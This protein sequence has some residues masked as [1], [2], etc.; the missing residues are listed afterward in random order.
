VN[1]TNVE[2]I[3]KNYL[4]PTNEDQSITATA[5]SPCEAIAPPSKEYSEQ[6][7]PATSAVFDDSTACPFRVIND[8][9]LENKI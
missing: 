4:F 3:K 5:E 6:L 7:S 2:L 1:T 9:P 8:F